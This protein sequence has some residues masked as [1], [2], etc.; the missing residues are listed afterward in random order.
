M[1]KKI[2]KR[3]R[4]A[5]RGEITDDA[6]IITT[7][8]KESHENDGVRK[9][10]IRTQIKNETLL[11]K[12][13]EASRIR[14]QQQDHKK[15]SSALKHKVNRSDKLQ[16]ILASKIDASIA[17]A[18]YVQNARKSNWDKTNSSIEIRNHMIE[19]GAKKELTQEDI[20]K[21]EEDE[22]VRKFYEDEV[23]ENKDD[24]GDGDE[25]DEK[26]TSVNNKFA[27]LDEVEA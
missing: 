11:S 16:G 17:R 26:K 6:P 13:I 15:K 7:S 1:A 14:K 24:G 25:D 21:M 10:I 2:S 12:K 4:A 8:T 20:D 19:E 3:S 5:R 23:V 18:K 9:S 27:L 22:Y